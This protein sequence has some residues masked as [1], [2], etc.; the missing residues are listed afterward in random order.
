[1]L[2]FENSYQHQ[3]LTWNP[4]TIPQTF[5]QVE[6]PEVLGWKGLSLKLRQGLDSVGQFYQQLVFQVG[7]AVGI[8]DGEPNGTKKS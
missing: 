6:D 3:L 5:T 8:I 7:E 1:M 2:E 4:K